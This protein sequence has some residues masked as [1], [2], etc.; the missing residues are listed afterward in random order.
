MASGAQP[1]ATAAD[2]ATIDAPTLLVPGTDPYH[3]PA[4]ADRYRDHLRRCTVRAVGDSEYAV[5]I[6]DF[7][8]KAHR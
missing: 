7:V 1:F 3:P 6:S 8:D 5:A 4:V 2:L